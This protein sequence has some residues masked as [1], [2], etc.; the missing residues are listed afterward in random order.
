MPPKVI[1][2]QFTKRNQYGDFKW[3]IQQEEYKNALFI[4]NDDIESVGSYKNGGGNACIREYNSNNPNIE[5]PQSAG[6]PTGSRKKKKG[7]QKLDSEAQEYIDTA[8]E[9]I[10][11]LIQKH[12]YETVFYS[13]DRD[14]ILG[15]KLFKPCD[16]VI[17]YITAKILELEVEC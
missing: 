11:G 8:L 9:K 15:S 10:K 14:G 3:M 7:F 2:T 13:A 16:D 1:P 17:V 4:F 12:S 6:I 5:I